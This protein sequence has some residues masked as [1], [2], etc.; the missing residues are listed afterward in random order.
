MSDVVAPRAV[1]LGPTDSVPGRTFTAVER[2]ELD[3]AVLRAILAD[4]R[5]LV[6]EAAAGGLP[7]NAYEVLDRQV[8]ARVMRHVVCVEHRL[9]SHPG[10]CVVGIFGQRRAALDITPLE[11]A[12]AALVREFAR[13]PG[14]TSYSSRE[15]PDGQWANLVLHDDPIDTEYW[16]RSELHSQAVQALS[17]VHYLSVRIHNGGLTAP[18]PD[19]PDLVLRVTKYFDFADGWRATRHL[20]T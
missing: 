8:D 9:R 1:V 11:Q 14:I 13:Y 6:Q 7:L 12:N 10:L 5:R 2:L 15:L 20:E 16:R 18:V 17:P 3:R 19:D 4:L